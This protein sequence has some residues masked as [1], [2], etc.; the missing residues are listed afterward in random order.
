MVVT[1]LHISNFRGIGQIDQEFHKRL[2]VF[3]GNN[4][5]GKS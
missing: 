2:N 4:G 1:E 3:I 5:S